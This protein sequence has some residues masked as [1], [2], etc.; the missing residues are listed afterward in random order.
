[1]T[2]EHN[3]F[4]MTPLIVAWHDVGIC[5]FFLKAIDHRPLV[6]HYMTTPEVMHYVHSKMIG[7]KDINSAAA[8]DHGCCCWFNKESDCSASKELSAMQQPFKTFYDQMAAEY[9]A[10]HSQSAT[11]NRTAYAIALLQSGLRLTLKDLQLTIGTTSSK[12]D[13]EL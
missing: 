10:T 4:S 9:I 6:L 7:E 3:Y 13:L 11:T 1:M 12:T 8:F 5:H 2:A